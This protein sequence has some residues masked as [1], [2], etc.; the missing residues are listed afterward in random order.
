[1]PN[2]ELPYLVPLEYAPWDFQCTRDAQ[3]GFFRDRAVNDQTQDIS[4]SF[5]AYVDSTLVGYLT[6]A[7]DAIELKRKE[8]P[9]SDIPYPRLPAV[10]LCQLAVHKDHERRGLGKKLVALAA[11]SALELKQRVGCRYLTVDAAEPWL[12]EW[13][14][15][16]EFKVNKID[17]AEKQTRA[18]KAGVDPATYTTSMRLDLHSLLLD[19]HDRFPRDFRDE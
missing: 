19:L 8:R 12:V 11:G 3:Q 9:S 17:E 16:Q 10:K 6:L 15:M 14:A 18:A 13:Y 4:R 7:M 1:M 2:D 5:L